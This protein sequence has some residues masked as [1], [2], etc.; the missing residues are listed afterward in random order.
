MKRQIKSTE[1]I[2]YM[3]ASKKAKARKILNLASQLF[4]LLDD[5][6]E[7]VFNEYDLQP[8]YDELNETIYDMAHKLRKTDPLYSG[9][10]TLD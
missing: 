8:L 10:N 6:P 3:N 2:V 7:E 9:K 1:S 5:S 4:D